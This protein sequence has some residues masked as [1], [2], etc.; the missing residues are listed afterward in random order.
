MNTSEYNKPQQAVILAGGLGMRLRPLTDNLPK[1]MIQFHGKPFLEYIL[2]MLVE[3]GFK[4]VVLLLG[5]LPNKVTEH[6]GNGKSF[7][8]DIEYSITDV[9]DDT[10]LRLQKAKHLFDPVFALLYCDNYW[11]MDFE[12]MWR[13]Y[14][15]VNVSALVTVYMNKDN[16]TKSN[17]RTDKNDFIELYDK[18]RLAPNLQGVDI[19]FFILKREL[20]DLIPEGNHNFEKTVI[21][22]LI[23]NRQIITYPTEHRYYSVGSHERL[24]LTDVFLE[25]RPTIIL[26]RDGVINRKAPK[27]QYITSWADWEWLKGAKEA[28]IKLKLAGYQIILVSNQAGIARGLMTHDD[29][30]DIHSHMINELALQ[31][32]GIDKIYY[33]PHGWDENCDCRKPKP[34]MLFQAQRDFH[35]DL[36][37]IWFVG[38]D[39]RDE[40]A[41]NA[42]GMETTLVNG[43]YG[44]LN[45]VTSQII[46]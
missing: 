45:F 4:R 10:G 9:E 27:A 32:G 17:I 35:L 30:A 41:G 1:P 37:K 29:L 6:F 22:K 2:E 7:G 20:I 15:S 33:C 42:A 24:K 12:K 3:Q 39:E 38:D 23:E 46:E 26:D 21:P 14:L 36:S 16:Y 18:T 5:Y 11:P 13:K 25:R 44:L 43:D 19:G 34:G 28:L 31:G 8:L 40:M